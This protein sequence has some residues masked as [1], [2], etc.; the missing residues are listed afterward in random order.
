MTATSPADPSHRRYDL[1]LL[2][3]VAFALLILYHVGMAYVADW[4]WHVKSGYLSEALQVPMG[5]L[6]RWR[7]PLLFLLAGLAVG[8]FDPRRLPLRFFRQRSARLLLPLGF[9]MLA[10]VPV[11]AYCQGVMNGLVAPGFGRFLLDYFSFQPWPQDAFDGWDSGLT[12]NHLWFLPYLWLYSV[13]LLG[14]LPLLESGRG[15]GFAGWLAGLPWWGLLLS[16]ALPAWAAMALLADRWPGKNNLTE[17][18]YQ[19]ALYFGIFLTGYLLARGQALWATVQAARWKLL[20][21]A[22]AIALLYFPILFSLDDAQPLDGIALAAVRLLRMLYMAAVLL[23]LLGWFSARLNRPRPW[24]AAAN[25]AVL[26]CY[27]L[28]QS[29]TVLLV[30]LLAP[31]GLGVAVE[32]SLVLGGTLAGCL[33][34]H[35]G[36]IRRSRWLRPLFGLKALPAPRLQ[37]LPAAA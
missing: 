8:L 30:Y 16:L 10:I 27:L 18:W 21:A 22:L 23:A 2:R 33:L 36:L 7:M 32:V 17:D 34:L 5:I 29:L 11:Q 12:W 37:P 15:Q 9:G 14:L 4:G 28:H 19:H 20:A 1:D 26:P 3:V 24:L 25:E 6:N 13:L 35:F 31:L